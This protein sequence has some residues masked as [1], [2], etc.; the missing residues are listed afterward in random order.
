MVLVGHVLDDDV[1][2]LRRCLRA[3]WPH[4]VVQRADADCWRD[5]D[6][7]ARPGDEF[8]VFRDAAA[9]STWNADGATTENADLMLHV[10]FDE[11]AATF[12]VDD[13]R[14]ELAAALRDVMDGLRLKRLPL[15]EV[16]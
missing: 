5:F 9:A 1:E 12:V 2:Y 14:G 8:F 15:R 4:A 16:A 13:D 11:A 6:S 3:L 10:L 7:T